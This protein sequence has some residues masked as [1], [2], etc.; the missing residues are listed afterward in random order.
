MN[1]RNI[2][3]T[4]VAVFVVVALFP[5]W[6]SWV[7]AGSGDPPELEKPGGDACV[8]ETEFMRESHM[9][10]LNQWRDEV[11]R[12]G[13]RFFTAAEGY[14]LPAGMEREEKSLSLTCLDCHSKAQFCDR[15]HDY[16]AITPNCWSCHVIPEGR[17]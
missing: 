4:A 15:C 7:S 11:V 17:E 6:G 3:L 1:D 16:S 5:F 10:L 12:D 2:I 8:M 14:T 13:E 9:D